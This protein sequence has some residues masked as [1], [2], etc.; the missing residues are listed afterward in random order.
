MPSPKLTAKRWRKWCQEN[1]IG[2]IYLAYTQS[3]EKVDPKEYGFDAAI[4]FPP[5]NSAP[6]DITDTVGSKN[7]DFNGTV[8]DWQVFVDKSKNIKPE[9]YKLFRGVNP[10]WDNTA[11]RDRNATIFANNSPDDYKMWLSR[12]ILDTIQNAKNPDEQII[13]INAWNEWAEGAYLEPDEQLGYA[14]LQAT[15]DAVEESCR[16]KDRIVLVGH[17]AH[18]HGAQALLLYLAKF[19]NGQLNFKVDV[20]LLGDGPMREEYEQFATVHLLSSQ[21]DF[22]KKERLLAQKLY[23][24]GARQAITNTAVSGYFSETLK[25]EGFFVTSLIHELPGVIKQFELETHLEKIAE[26]SDA[27]VFPAVQSVEGFSTIQSVRSFQDNHSTPGLVLEKINFKQRM[28]K[29]IAKTMLRNKFNLPDDAF[30]VLCIGYADHRKGIDLFAQIAK[31]QC[32]KRKNTYFVWVGHSDETLIPE[33][34]NFINENNL[35]ERIFFPGLDFDSDLYYAGADVYALTSREDPFPSVILEAMDAGLPIV[36]FDGISGACET[37]GRSGGSLIPPFNLDLFSNAIEILATNKKLSD[38]IAVKSRKIISE[39]FSFRKYAIS[40]LT[41]SPEYQ[42]V[43][44][45]VP[46]YN[47]AHY[48]EERIDSIVSQNYPLWEIILLD[49]ASTDGSIEI[50]QNAAKNL[51]IDCKLVINDSNS[52]SVFHQWQRGVEMASGDFVWIAE[53]DDLSEIDFLTTAMNGFN[54]KNT[55]LSYT[56]S[57]QVDEA[58][59]VL[60]N[61]YLDYVKDISA[62]KWNKDYVNSGNNEICSALAI[63]NTIPNVSASVFRKSNIQKVLNQY[64]DVICSYKVAGDWITY[65]YLLANGDLS[66]SCKPL[67]KHR[68]HGRSVTIGSYDESQLDEILRV[69]QIAREQFDVDKSVIEKAR[70]YAENLYDQF[71]IGTPGCPKIENHPKLSL[72]LGVNT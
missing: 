51:N 62:S 8:Y 72:Y 39:E 12:S 22:G 14:Y 13:F 54:H 71:C 23:N 42:K 68:R 57:K 19:F 25:K 3:F 43:S 10:S 30:V 6:P 63:K 17:D 26:Y 66:F 41:T 32:R 2:D 40:L 55:V 11:R 4:E 31:K 1:G 69:Q 49:D 65:I 21:K 28:K 34:R 7:P 18:P 9:D 16:P 35:A 67:N 47:Y 46:N 56:E 15:R 50:L 53:A 33:V 64:M 24:L 36:M 70:S 29:I 60:C 59:E 5:N 52:G 20:I 48:L 61:N 38:D 44:V 37:V 58:G 45:V 27:V